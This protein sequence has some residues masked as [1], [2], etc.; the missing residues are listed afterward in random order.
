VF[1]KA[2]GAAATLA[3]NRK[4]FDALVASVRPGT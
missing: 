1:F 3:A 4:A 2:T